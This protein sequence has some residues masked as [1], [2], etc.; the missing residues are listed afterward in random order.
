MELLGPAGRSV[1]SAVPWWPTAG[2]DQ[3][4]DGASTNWKNKN[5]VFLILN[6]GS[7]FASDLVFEHTDGFL[8]HTP[9]EIWK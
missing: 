5:H 1:F 7:F 2:N 9:T 8:S 4:T 3:E 6:L